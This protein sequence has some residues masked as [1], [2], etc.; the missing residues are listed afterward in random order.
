MKYLPA[1]YLA[2]P[3]LGLVAGWASAPRMDVTAGN[4]SADRR[5]SQRGD[6]GKPWMPDDFTNSLRQRLGKPVSPAVDPLMPVL[7]DWTDGEILTAL[8]ESML[9]PEL[10]FGSGDSAGVTHNL[11]RQLIQRDFAAASA[12][13]AALPQER[14]NA[15]SATLL[16]NWPADR[17]E[18]GYRF[19]RENPGISTGREHRILNI[20][21][22]AAATRGAAQMLAFMRELKEEGFG[23]G[24]E[25]IY[26]VNAGAIPAVSFPPGFDFP[27]FLSSPDV[28]LPPH[29]GAAQ[30]AALRA[31]AEQ[32]RD[33]SFQ[34][35]LENRGAKAL[36][37]AENPWDFTDGTSTW[38][39][40]K[41]AALPPA[42][43]A[44]YL[45]GRLASWTQEPAYARRILQ[46]SRESPIH[47]EI[48]RHAVQGIFYGKYGS[49][50]DLIS[51]LPDPAER[52]RFLENLER[53]EQEEGF[54][55]DAVQ[56]DGA[57]LRGKLRSWGAD[58]VR[59]EAILTHLKSQVKKEGA[60]P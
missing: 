54:H 30:D 36:R 57:A 3:L 7:E 19:I 42:Q 21:L 43:R 39:S 29:G 27:S 47:Q 45:G 14:Q 1:L 37:L 2:V 18:E 48:L 53:M 12:W 26:A 31:W 9:H 41:L 32:D 10:M 35:L 6:T 33:A 15:L 11:F 28:E 13:F 49:S 58:E 22:T 16:W 20:N 56:V 55:M 44:E 5:S 25:I 60:E 34:W 17:P 46:A 4:G 59:T 8:D 52:I 23:G 38:F 24:F 50:L 51:G 40:G